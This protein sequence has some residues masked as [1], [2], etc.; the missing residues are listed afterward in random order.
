MKRHSQSALWIGSLVIRQG[1][2]MV[3]KGLW[4]L[5]PWPCDHRLPLPLLDWT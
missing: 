3:N 4:E 2:I 5:I 1:D